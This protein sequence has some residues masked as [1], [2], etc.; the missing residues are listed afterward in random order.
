MAH[1][2]PGGGTGERRDCVMGLQASLDTRTAPFIAAPHGAPLSRSR[3]AGEIAIWV[4]QSGGRGDAGGIVT[5]MGRDV[6]F[7]VL[8][9]GSVARPPASA[10]EPDRPRTLVRRAGPPTAPFRASLKAT[11][12]NAQR[13]LCIWRHGRQMF[14]LP[15]TIADVRACRSSYRTATRGQMRMAWPTNDRTGSAPK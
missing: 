12:N 8:A 11:S 15:L 10:I 7:F 1:A 14:I 9:G 5:R 4:W 13:C 3:L 2:R 6:G